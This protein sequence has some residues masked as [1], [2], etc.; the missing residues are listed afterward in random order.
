MCASSGAV[1]RKHQEF[2]RLNTKDQA[3]ANSGGLQGVPDNKVPSF[4]YMEKHAAN[5]FP[6]ATLR[7]VKNH[8]LKP[9]GWDVIVEQFDPNSASFPRE[10]QEGRA[11]VSPP[12]RV[13]ERH[14]TPFSTTKRC[15]LGLLLDWFPRG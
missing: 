5:L 14:R 6:A 3:D 8:V 11:D 12:T 13:A 2:L 7:F 10:Y 15:R 9:L 4:E 1:G